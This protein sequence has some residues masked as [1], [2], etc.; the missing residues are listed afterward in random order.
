[1][2]VARFRDVNQGL[3]VVLAVDVAEGEHLR[4]RKDKSDDAQTHANVKLIVQ[5]YTYAVQ[6]QPA[7]HTCARAR[8][9]AT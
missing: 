6:I 5:T 9:L 2:R 4:D 7:A 8:G 3:T 1:M